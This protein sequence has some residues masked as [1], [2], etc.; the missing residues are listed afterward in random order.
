MHNPNEVGLQL[1]EENS[2]IARDDEDET[3]QRTSSS[4]DGSEEDGIDLANN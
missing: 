3:S 2:L 1:D 4:F